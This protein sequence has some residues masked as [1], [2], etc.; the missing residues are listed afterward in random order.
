MQYIE[1]ERWKK[2]TKQWTKMDSGKRFQWALFLGACH[3]KIF[4]EEKDFKKFLEK[5]VSVR[6][7]SMLF[8]LE[9]SFLFITWSFVHLPWCRTLLADSYKDSIHLLKL[10]ASLFLFGVYN[11]KSIISI[12]YFC[13][14]FLFW[15]VPVLLC[16]QSISTRFWNEIHTR[17]GILNTRK[18]VVCLPAGW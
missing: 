8:T 15:S 3:E 13:L 14:H 2:E 9:P 17:N 5:I 10:P 11:N 7:V 4:G 1:I 18:W 16:Y 6:A 12:M